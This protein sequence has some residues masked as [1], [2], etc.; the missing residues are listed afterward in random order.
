MRT[1]GIVGL[2]LIGGSLGLA[3]RRA[4]T[5]SLAGFDTN[6]A[7]TA[8]AF[9]RGAIDTVASTYT[10]LHECSCVVLAVPV[11]QMETVFSKL[12][13]IQRSEMVVTDVGGVKGPILEL[14]SKLPYPSRFVGG[15]PMAGREQGGVANA[16]SSLFEGRPWILTPCETTSDDAVQVVRSLVEAIGATPV[17]IDPARHDAEIAVLSHLPHVIASALMRVAGED[18]RFDLAGPSWH[19]ATRVATS[20]PEMWA[21]IAMNN[22]LHLLKAVRRLERAIGEFSNALEAEDTDTVL[23]LFEVS[24]TLKSRELAPRSAKE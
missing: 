20:P 11:S 19:G 1:V 15:H 5:F 7:S 10:D 14:A 16:D 18:S 13:P 9:E 4:G 12:A 22:R 23:R 8:A 3:L 6:P 21:R 17:I 24:S 2:G